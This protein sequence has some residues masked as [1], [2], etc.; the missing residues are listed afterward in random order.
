MK[1]KCTQC[2]CEDLE[3]IDKLQWLPADIEVIEIVK[4]LLN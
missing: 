1:I 2:G 4:D 3:E